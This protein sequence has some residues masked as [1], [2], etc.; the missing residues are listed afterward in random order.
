MTSPFPATTFQLCGPLRQPRQMLADQKYDGHKSIH[1]DAMAE[2]LG[3]RAGPIE[4]PTHFSQFDP[5]LFE[6]FGQAW[7]ET[8]CI[9][10]H[11]QNMVVEGESVRAF[12]ERPAPGATFVRLRAEKADGTP[13]L[14]GTASVGDA[15]AHPHE[16]CQ[17]IAKLRPPTGLVINR[18]LKVGQRGAV[19][20]KIRMGFDQD[21]GEHYPFTLNDKLKVIT[22]PCDWYT[23][24]GG[25]RSPWGR[26][27]I[28]TEMISVLLGSTIAEAQLGGR[29]PAVGLFAGQEI[30]LVKG[31]L[32]V[33]TDYELEREIVALSESARTESVWVRTKV[34]ELP[35][36][37]L[38]AEMI[39]NGATMKASYPHY[40]A[41]A[42]ALEGNL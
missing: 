19:T 20:E 5:L 34:Y 24:E 17:R 3:L 32:F 41:E 29:K 8:G 25:Q 12:V 33:G 35:S 1:D 14:Q 15:S 31:P 22:E 27:I 11:Y 39:L 23:P 42:K 28:P 18:D 4:G 26:A 9:S 16:L 37:T 40:E 30:S 10:A 13:V 38:V 7:F 2:G 36:R 6:L 21:M